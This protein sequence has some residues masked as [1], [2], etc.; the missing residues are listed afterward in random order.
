MATYDYAW[1]NEFMG[2]VQAL[3]DKDVVRLWRLC[4]QLLEGVDKEVS[5]YVHG[6][7]LEF[8]RSAVW[9]QQ[10]ILFG[11]VPIIEL[12]ASNRAKAVALR[13]REEDPL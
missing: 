11:F 3:N 8:W 2:K 5:W 9:S 6:L 1:C 4:A 10:K 12:V 7:Y 13:A